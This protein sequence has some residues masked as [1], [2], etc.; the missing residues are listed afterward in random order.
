[1]VLVTG[2]RRLLFLDNIAQN[3]ATELLFPLVPL[4][5]LISPGNPVNIDG[6]Q[7]P[8]VGG[9]LTVKVT[10]CRVRVKWASELTSNRMPPFP[11]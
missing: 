4:V 3:V 10:L 8:A 2:L 11:L 7:F 6:G 1:M 5:C 9:L